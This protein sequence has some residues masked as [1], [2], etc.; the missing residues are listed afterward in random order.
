MVGGGSS[1]ESP[2]WGRPPYFWTLSQKNWAKS[3]TA[4]GHRVPN[5]T[6]RRLERVAL[7]Q[8]WDNSKFPFVTIITITNFYES[9][10]FDHRP[11]VIT[12]SSWFRFSSWLACMPLCYS[13]RTVARQPVII[14][15]SGR[16]N[17]GAPSGNSGDSNCDPI[18]VDV[19]TQLWWGRNR[20]PGVPQK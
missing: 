15:G 3:P 10:D 13:L 2:F 20:A 5:V 17:C 9:P 19:G 8:I 16:R 7:I 14:S 1:L 11:F 4:G 6:W 12:K 18:V